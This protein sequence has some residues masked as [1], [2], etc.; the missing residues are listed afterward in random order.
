MSILSYS[1][2]DESNR[3]TSEQHSAATSVPVPVQL[4]CCPICKTL[5]KEIHVTPCGHS[6][7]FSCIKKHLEIKQN[8]PICENC[9][10]LHETHPNFLLNELLTKTLDNES[11]QG[12][13]L[14]Y[15]QFQ[16]EVQNLVVRCGNSMGSDEFEKLVQI[17]RKQQ[18]QINKVNQQAQLMLMHFFLQHAREEKK[19]HIQ[20]LQSQL[21][22][23]NNDILCIVRQSADQVPFFHDSS[24]DLS[25]AQHAEFLTDSQNVQQQQQ[26]QQQQCIKDVSEGSSQNPM[27]HSTYSNVFSEEQIAN[28][29]SSETEVDRLICNKKTRV[30]Q[31]FDDL[32]NCYL[33]LLKPIKPDI[34]ISTKAQQTSEVQPE[35]S[36]CWPSRLSVF[37]DTLSVV[38]TYSNL[39]VVTSFECGGVN[40]ST[41]TS[42][43]LSA[44]EFC[45]NNQN[46]ATAG[47]QQQI[48]L[49]DFYAIVKYGGEGLHSIVNSYKT[50]SK[51]SS[52][53]WSPVQTC[54]LISGGYDEESAPVQ[55][56]RIERVPPNPGGCPWLA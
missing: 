16:M 30:I 2:K 44:I 53:S 22:Q 32:M 31:R 37:Q 40:S 13:L 51:T 12:G 39:D 56:G 41:D 11:Q 15:H 25:D 19:Q 55:G 35:T 1:V 26:Q 54:T 23:L 43:I 17:I 7:C 28:K 42:V 6:F 47:V 27:P 38:A 14:D 36:E 24:N 20:N 46:F 3:Y 34:E 45:A 49:Y 52:L 9:L 5:L 4:F 8:C 29:D 50:Q 21:N 33:S 10:E 18:M 48:D